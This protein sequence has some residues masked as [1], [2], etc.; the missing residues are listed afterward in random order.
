MA[1]KMGSPRPHWA[2]GAPEDS[3][4]KPTGWMS[5]EPGTRQHLLVLISEDTPHHG[6]SDTEECQQQHAGLWALVEVRQV[7]V[8]DPGGDHPSASLFPHLNTTLS[9]ARMLACA[10]HPVSALSRSPDYV[11]CP[12]GSRIATPKASTPWL[13]ASRS[14]RWL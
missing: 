9:L 12:S 2:V 6:D 14:H 10:C 7:V 1:L 13:L 3:S 8:G 5:A 11:A 4:E